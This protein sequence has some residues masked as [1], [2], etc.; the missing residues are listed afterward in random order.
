[1]MVETSIA[2]RWALA[3][4]TN[5][6]VALFTPSSSG[7]TAFDRLARQRR[8]AGADESAALDALRRAQFRLLR[9]EAVGKEIARLRDLATGDVLP[10]LDDSIKAEAVG[11]ALV[12]RLTPAGRRSLARPVL[13]SPP[14]SSALVG[15]GC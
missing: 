11:L 15:A 13:R 7:A 5:M 4:S 8:G 14:A 1:M 9:V 2:P 3:S 6:D 10:V 12:G